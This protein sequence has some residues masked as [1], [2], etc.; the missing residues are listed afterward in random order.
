MGYTEAPQAEKEDGDRERAT[1]RT[2]VQRQKGGQTERDTERQ[3]KQPRMTGAE[4]R[5]ER[6]REREREKEREKI[7]H[8]GFDAGMVLKRQS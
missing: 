7:V 2:D 5:R 8:T 1:G 6:G 4:R 3:Q